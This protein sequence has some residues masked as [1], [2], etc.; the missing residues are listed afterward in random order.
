MLV[1][2]NATTARLGEGV[3]SFRERRPPEWKGW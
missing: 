1:E 3:A 2:M